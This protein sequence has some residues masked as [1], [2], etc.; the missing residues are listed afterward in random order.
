MLS[1][2]NDNAASAVSCI[3]SIMDSAGDYIA[4]L[5]QT[6]YC[7]YEYGLIVQ[8]SGPQPINYGMGSGYRANKHGS[9]FA[10]E[11]AGPNLIPVEINRMCVS[12]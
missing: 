8:S 9:L 2:D 11:K 7:S 4:A 5:V 10:V 6:N 3:M 12:E 1:I